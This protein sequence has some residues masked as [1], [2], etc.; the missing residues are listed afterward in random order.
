MRIPR[1][2]ICCL[3][4]ILAVAWSIRAQAQDGTEASKSVRDFVQ[5]FYSWYVPEAVKEHKGPAWDPAL[6]YKSHTFSTELLR[7][8]KEDSRAQAR[9]KGVIIGL[10]FDPFLNTQD[11]CEGYELGNISRK[12][13]DYWV[14]VY[15]VCSGKRSEHPDVVCEVGRENG[16]WVFVNFLYENMMKEYPNSA[17]LLATLKLL[18]EERKHNSP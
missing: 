16:N 8:L 12:E 13:N 10:D 2:I 1:S 4:P 5:E 15:S 6:K 7:A 18:Q 3:W 17:N 11:P 9:V 14:E